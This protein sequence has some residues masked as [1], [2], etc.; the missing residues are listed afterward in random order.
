MM[1]PQPEKTRY[2]TPPGDRAPFSPHQENEEQKSMSL[3]KCGSPFRQSGPLVSF[4]ESAGGDSP[5]FNHQS[6]LFDPTSSQN[7]NNL[8]LGIPDIV[9]TEMDPTMQSPMT[10]AEY[11]HHQQMDMMS[12]HN[13]SHRTTTT[14]AMGPP[15]PPQQ[16]QQ[17]QQQ[18]QRFGEVEGQQGEVFSMGFGAIPPVRFRMKFWA[19]PADCVRPLA[20]VLYPCK[21]WPLY[22]LACLPSFLRF[23]PLAFFFFSFVT[24]RRYPFF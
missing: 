5:S 11:H 17:Q 16:Q 12:E 1:I 13:H 3:A 20:L 2:P 9:I 22:H 23:F 6:L 21:I 8:S 7:F 18:Q 24:W 14:L 10:P 15:P 4:P 19:A